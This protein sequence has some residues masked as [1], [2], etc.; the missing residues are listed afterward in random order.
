MIIGNEL[1]FVLHAAASVLFTLISLRLGAEALAASVAVQMLLANLF[2]V[3]EMVWFGFQITCSDPFVI[4]S[5]L[6]LNLLQEYFGRDKA[7][8]AIGLSFITSLFLM[9]F[10]G[11]V[12]LY[13]PSAFDSMHP[14]L[15]AIFS[16][17]PR[18]VIASLFV[19]VLVQ[20]IDVMLYG[21]LKKHF[22]NRFLWVRNTASMLTTQGIDTLLFS[23]L[24]LYGI[25]H[26]IWDIVLIS[27]LVKLC[28]IVI[29]GPAIELSRFIVKPKQ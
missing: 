26:Q 20:Y 7:R 28:T 29:A 16:H 23:F 3:K 18:I 14:H 6:S 1:V 4:G 10:G 17:T 25:V 24:G 8:E 27:F 22:G 11:I 15:Q 12:V 19:A 9:V 2:V 5:A 13:T 21:M